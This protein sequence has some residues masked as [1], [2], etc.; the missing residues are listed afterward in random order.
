MGKTTECVGELQNLRIFVNAACSVVLWVLNRDE[1]HEKTSSS[2]QAFRFV[3]LALQARAEHSNSI[4]QVS[5]VWSS[6]TAWICFPP[7]VQEFVCV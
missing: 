3:K 5:A 6:S 4:T 7:H 2:R 1:S